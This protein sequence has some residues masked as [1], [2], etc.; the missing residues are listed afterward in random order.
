MQRNFPN[1]KYRPQNHELGSRS[2]AEASMS[3]R[4][5]ARLSQNLALLLVDKNFESVENQAL[6]SLSSLMK[7]YLLE[8]GKEIKATS[9]IQG[10][11][12]S[13][14]I[15]SLNVAYDYGMQQRDIESHIEQNELTLAPS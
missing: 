10:R 5:D 1:A 2:S 8:I 14:L 6:Y 7:D 12:E 9:E 3:D 4:L 13:T 15:D 11:T